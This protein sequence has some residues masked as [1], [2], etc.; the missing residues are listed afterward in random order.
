MAV[1][2]R[3]LDVELLIFTS[4]GRLCCVIARAIF[5]HLESRLQIPLD[6]LMREHF[7][8]NVFSVSAD[9]DVP[10]YQD[11]VVQGKLETTS[12]G[13]YGRYGIAWESLSVIIGLLSAVT[14]LVAQL[15]VLA[16]VV[17]SQQDGISFATMH[18]FQELSKFLLTPNWTFSRTNGLSPDALSFCSVDHRSTATDISIQ[19]GSRS[20]ITNIMSSFRA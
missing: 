5:E 16:K 13:P 12:T 6:Q 8:K 11:K 3:R 20:L 14:R 19:L 18:F 9:L 1:D 17:G 7:E 15:G 2:E 10:T 4:V